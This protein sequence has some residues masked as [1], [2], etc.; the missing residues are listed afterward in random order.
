MKIEHLAIWV[1]DLDKMKNFYIKYF[2]AISNEKYNNPKTGLETYFLSF[3]SGSRIEIMKRP[4]VVLEPNNYLQPSQGLAHFAFEMESTDKVNELTTLL[5]QDGFVI[6]GEP[7]ITGDGYY[8]SVLLDPE[9]NS[10]EI[11]YNTKKTK[12]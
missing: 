4:D 3:N 1:A 6:T 8:E 12:G 2:G 9:N 10:I 5:R 11:I 7:R